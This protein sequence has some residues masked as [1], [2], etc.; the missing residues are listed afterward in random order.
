VHIEICGAIPTFARPVL[1]FQPQARAKAGK[2]RV[3]VD[4]VVPAGDSAATEVRRLVELGA[5]VL[6]EDKDLPWVV[7]ADPEGNEFS[8]RVGSTTPAQPNPS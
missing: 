1:V 5:R 6:A 7:L 3:H 4:V 8:V 2:N